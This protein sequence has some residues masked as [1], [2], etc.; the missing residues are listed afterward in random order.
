MQVHAVWAVWTGA[1]APL[2]SVSMPLPYAELCQDR[3]RVTSHRPT[4]RVSRTSLFLA[5]SPFQAP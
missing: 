3:P 5:G 1:A 2:V 4:G